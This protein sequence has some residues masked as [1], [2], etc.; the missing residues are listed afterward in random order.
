V[1]A[2]G[3][4]KE[5]MQTTVNQDREASHEDTS[6]HPTPTFRTKAKRA[7]EIGEELLVYMVVSFF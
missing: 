5:A 6:K 1:K 2:Q 3:T 4:T 7:H